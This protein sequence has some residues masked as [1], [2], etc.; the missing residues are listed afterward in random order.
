MLPRWH[1]LLGALFTFI[2]WIVFPQTKVIYLALIFLASFLIDFDHYAASVLKTSEFSLFRSFKYHEI[3]GRIEKKEKAR[4]IKRKGDFHLFHTIEVHILVLL[5][6]YLWAG[7][8]YI[9]IGMLF[10]SIIDLVDLTY[11]ERLYRREYF[12]VNWLVKEVK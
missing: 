6:S 11:G 2:V 8:L 10:H 5:L 1:I 9:F 7:F 12:L 3:L 4:G